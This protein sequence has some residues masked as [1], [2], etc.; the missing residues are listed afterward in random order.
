VVVEQVV[1]VDGRK[2]HVGD[3]G[4]L[5]AFAA[6]FVTCA[7][8]VDPQ[9]G[10]QVLAAHALID[11]EV[12]AGHAEDALVVQRAGV[13]RRHAQSRSV[14][15]HVREGG[16]LPGGILREGSLPSAG[17]DAADFPALDIVDGAARGVQADAGLAKSPIRAGR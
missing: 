15:G 17:L 9:P 14:R 4:I 8:I 16:H 5:H 6:H 2:L 13:D 7:G 1:P 3:P 11:V 10:T 12:R